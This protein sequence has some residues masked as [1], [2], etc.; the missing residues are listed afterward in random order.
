MSSVAKLFFNEYFS[1]QKPIDILVNSFFDEYTY[2]T[3]NLMFFA[4]LK[5]N[6]YQCIII[7]R[8]KQ[9]RMNLAFLAPQYA[10]EVL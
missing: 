1:S 6:M 5:L 8:M 10:L 4:L 7:L 3:L 2:E 9:H